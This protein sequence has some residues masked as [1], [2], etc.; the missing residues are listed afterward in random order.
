MHN[1]LPIILGTVAVYLALFALVAFKPKTSRIMLVVSAGLTV[2]AGLILFSLCFSTIFDSIPL[3]ITHTCYAVICL[4]LGDGAP[5]I[6]SDSPLMQYEIVQ[7]LSVALSFLAVFTTA[8]AA[9]STIGA[10][11]LRKARAYLHRSKELAVIFSLTPNTLEFARELTENKDCIVVFVDENP[12]SACVESAKELGCLIRSDSNALSGNLAFLRSIGMAKGKRKI[13]L[14]TLSPNHFLNRSY[15]SNFLDAL[16]QRG[17]QPNRTGLTIFAAED[18]TETA[19]SGSDYSF[20]RV[21]CVNPEYIAARLLMK[22][23][24]PY[25]TMSFGDDCR[26]TEDFHALVIGCGNV[27]QAVIKQLIMNGQFVGSHFRLDVFDPNFYS[28]NGRLLHECGLLFDQYDIQ[29]HT[30]DARSERMYAFLSEHRNTLKYI[31]I[32]TGSDDSNREISYQINHFLEMHHISLPLYICST[33]GL[34]KIDSNQTERWDLYTSEVLCSD[35]LDNMATLLN[36]YY[37]NNDRRPAANWADCDY[38]SRMSSRAS[39]DFASAFLKMAGMQEENLPETNWVS[40]ERLENLAI[41]EHERWCAFHY[42]M[43][44]RP[45][46]DEEFFTRCDIFRKEVEANPK[47]RYRIDKDIPARIHYC[48]IPWEDLDALSEREKAVTGKDPKLKA[49]DRNNVLALPELL[50]TMRS[51]S[52]D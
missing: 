47:T 2:V 39:A 19:F 15:A 43:G 44:F 5:D 46:T 26:A 49:L 22:K 40:G 35:T 27:G 50:K 52:Y 38:F 45:M 7:L 17:I 8:G 25:E 10:N 3:S 12:D 23:A 41:T 4:F 1:T 31:V 9:I 21:L 29:V 24:P 14:Y 33:R 30:D 28:V 42:C 11:F 6:L 37:C 32:S 18:T 34:Q 48:L 13:T 20:G 16:R 36:H 51:E